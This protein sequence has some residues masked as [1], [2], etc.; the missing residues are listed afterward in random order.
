MKARYRC[1][2]YDHRGQGQSP[3]SPTP[4]DMETLAADAAALIGALGAAPVHFVGL[5]MGGFVGMRLAIQSRSS[6]APSS[7]STPPP[8]PSRAPTSPSTGR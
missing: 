5:S 6:S 2:T 1:V 8:T 7:S 3:A 4:Y